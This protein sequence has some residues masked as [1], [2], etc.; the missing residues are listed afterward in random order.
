MCLSYTSIIPNEVLI[1]VY[2]QSLRQGAQNLLDL[3]VL[4]EERL[5][6]LTLRVAPNLHVDVLLEPD[7]LL[8]DV[9]IGNLQHGR[10]LPLGE[11][12][13]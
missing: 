5:G 1:S 8:T 10:L 11:L 13:G 7:N 4:V 6:E 9:G 3:L 12:I 2:R